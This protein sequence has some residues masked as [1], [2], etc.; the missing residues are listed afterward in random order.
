MIRPPMDLATFAKKA[1][2]V[3]N[4]L[5]AMGNARRLMVLCKLVEHG[6]MTVGDLAR[7]VGL[8]QSAL[9]QH[10]DALHAELQGRFDALHEAGPRPGTT[11]T[12][13]E[14]PPSG[15]PLLW[16]AGDSRLY[17]ITHAAATPLTVDHVPATVLA[18][19]GLI[20]EDA[21]WRHVH[22]SHAPQ[23]AQA[24]ILGN[25]LT[26]PARLDDG[27]VGLDAATLPP[28]LRALPDR[29]ALGLRPD[30]TYLLATDG[31]W[32][33]R[34]PA[35]FVARWPRLFAHGDAQAGLDALFAEM[36]ER[37]PVGLQPDNLTAIVLRLRQGGNDET[38]LPG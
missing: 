32:S 36:E 17:E 31:F 18:M 8:S 6:E 38:A 11:L 30:A 10:L 37:P 1:G 15:S 33:C 9:S 35:E 23:I 14:I 4:L 22:G 16:H 34:D 29:R 5:K 20:D 19:A 7:E 26:D 25:T 27:L 12:M 2:E 21:W 28:W 3:S 24:F 13:L